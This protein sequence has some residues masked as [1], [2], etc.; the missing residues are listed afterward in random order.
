MF[1]REISSPFEISNLHPFLDRLNLRSVLSD[2]EQQA[3]LG[4]PAFAGQVRANDDH[5]AL[6]ALTDHATMVVQGVLG[7][8][9]QNAAATARSPPC[10]W[11]ATWPTCN[12]LSSRE[13]P[14]R[15]RR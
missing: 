2:E 4:L 10:T 3:V 7:R 1:L 9:G 15:S 11:P 12:R 13:P 5:V 6:G 8:F 14:R